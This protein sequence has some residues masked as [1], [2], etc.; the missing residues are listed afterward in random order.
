MLA[1]H[2]S[3]HFLR[4]LDSLEF[5]SLELVTPDGRQRF[6]E[7]KN[8]G[9][10]ASMIVHQWDVIKNMLSRGDIGFV[11]SY[12][13]GHCETNNLQNLFALALKNESHI[14][15]YLFGS[16]AFQMLAR[17]SYLLKLNTIKG[18][19]RNI[20]A[21]Y[22]LGNDFYDLWLDPS[23]TYSSALFKNGN[24]TLEQAQNNKY[25]RIIERLGRD[26]GSLLEIGCGWGGFA[27]RA[28]FKGGF[29]MRGITLSEEQHDFAKQRL[30]AK[31]D[32]VLEDYRIQKGKFD[33]IVSIE[34]F[35][36][37]GERYW[38]IYFNKVKSLMADKGK[39]VVQTITIDEKHFDRYRCGGDAIRSY[40]FPG[41][42]LPSPS[43]FNREV[44]KAGMKVSDEFYFG[45]DYAKTLEL[46][47]NTFDEKQ[48]EIKDLGFDNSFIRLWR[49]YLAAC[50]A[51]FET[52]RINVMQAEMEHA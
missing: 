6:F 15:K 4:K 23:M 19:K 38:P 48:K 20:H 26:D 25:D 40:I 29:D 36:A 9:P 28:A 11:E 21:H 44:E 2:I 10:R 12:R 31:A 14:K 42:M 39:A 16:S 49:F 51:G 37:V 52:G 47:L 43:R 18:S 24:E 5:G 45:K 17:L 8:P 7:G 35:E 32:I 1:S 22:D 46:W 41:G 50:I 13:A 33:N 30:G 3:D 27:E 34:M